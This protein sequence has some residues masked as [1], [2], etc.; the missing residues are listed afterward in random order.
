M[1]REDNKGGYVTRQHKHMAQ[2]PFGPCACTQNM[3]LPSCHKT[4]KIKNMM[5]ES[6]QYESSNFGLVFVRRE[7]PFWSIDE[8]KWPNWQKN[9]WIWKI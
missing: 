6:W 7:R 1:T 9:I 2:T 8:P 5:A 3:G 4:R